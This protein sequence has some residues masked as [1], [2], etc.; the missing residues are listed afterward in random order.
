MDKAHTR[1]RLLAV[2]PRVARMTTALH[3]LHAQASGPGRGVT[4]PWMRAAVALALVAGL[5]MVGGSPSAAEPV[6]TI[7]PASGLTDWQYVRVQGSGFEPNTLMEYFQCRGGA[8]DE[9]DCDGYNADFV[10]SDG[11]GNVDFTYPVD[12]RIYLPDG[13]E[14]DCRTDPA[15]C[16]I[17]I[18]YM[19]DADEWPAAALPFDPTAPLRPLVTATATP[20][21]G[22]EDGDVVTVHG[23][24]VLPRF[25]TWAFQCAAGDAM[26]GRRCNL[27]GESRGVADPGTETIDLGLEVHRRFVTP[28]GDQIDC[29]TAPGGCEIVLSWGFS[30]QPDRHATVALSFTGAPPTTTASTVAPTPPTTVPA[31]PSAPP[32]AP[33]SGR[34]TFTG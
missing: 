30:N 32:A 25:E 13:T 16:E 2:E 23:A 10:D 15:G 22:L 26:W 33:E 12:A 14:V 3:A 24:G 5:T 17:G 7:T 31:S 6:I 20:D 11:A 19:M 4:T 18:G 21:S 34:P 1:R 27:D 29:D 8:V 9:N 28:F